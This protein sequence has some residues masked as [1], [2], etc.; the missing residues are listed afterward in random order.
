[1][2]KN[3]EFKFQTTKVPGHSG[4]RHPAKDDNEKR[5]RQCTEANEICA[6]LLDPLKKSKLREASDTETLQSVAI[7]SIVY[8]VEQKSIHDGSEKSAN[9]WKDMKPVRL[10]L[11]NLEKYFG[12]Q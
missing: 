10:P 3:A 2:L 12:N 5:K 6:N 7:N 9:K 8:P 4:Y 1:M 11:P